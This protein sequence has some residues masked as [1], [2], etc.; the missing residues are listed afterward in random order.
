MGK[1]MKNNN[2]YTPT[3]QL[4]R[5]PKEV[6]FDASAVD[7]GA[8]VSIRMHKLGRIRGQDVSTLLNDP[9]EEPPMLT[10]RSLRSIDHDIINMIK[11]NGPKLD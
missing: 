2:D 6:D 3:S 11:A 10:G 4:K 8:N 5:S 9:D 1:G 7:Q